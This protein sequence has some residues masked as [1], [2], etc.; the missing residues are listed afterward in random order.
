MNY[1]HELTLISYEMSKDDIGNPIKVPVKKTILCRLA[2]VGSKEFYDAANIGLKPEMKFIVH[3]FEYN[4]EKDVIFEDRKYKVMRTYTESVKS[5]RSRLG[6]EEME[7]TCE[8][9]VGDG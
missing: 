3:E 2:S 4:G 6:M 9:V 7:L 8:R 5:E 1:N